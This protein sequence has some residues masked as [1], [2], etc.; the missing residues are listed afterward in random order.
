ML[1]AAQQAEDDILAVQRVAREATGLSQTF[2]AGAVTGGVPQVVGAYPSQ[3]EQTLRHYPQDGA[4]GAGTH[5]GSSG[6]PGSGCGLTCFGCG[7]NHAW[8]EF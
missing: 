2:H 7:G 6:T 4:Q 3:A 1:Q 5:T 8:S